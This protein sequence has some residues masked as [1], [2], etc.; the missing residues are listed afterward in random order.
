MERIH[1]DEDI[2]TRRRAIDGRVNA[3]DLPLRRRQSYAVRKEHY[4]LLLVARK[5][6]PE[7]DRG[8]SGVRGPQ[9]VRIRSERRPELGQLER[10]DNTSTI[11]RVQARRRVWITVGE[12]GVGAVGAQAVIDPFPMRSQLTPGR[13]RKLEV[14]ERSSK[15]EAGPAR[16]DRGPP[17]GDQLVDLGVCQPCVLGDRAL[18]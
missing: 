7:D 13:R 6:E 9:A 3:L 14:R 10:T 2:F 1:Q 5:L 8:V 4:F 16:D 17:P 11:V 15:I 12:D 18:M